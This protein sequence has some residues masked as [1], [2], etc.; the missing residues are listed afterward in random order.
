MPS[1][2]MMFTTVR[3]AYGQ[4]AKKSYVNVRRPARLTR[5]I[6]NKNCT[7]NCNNVYKTRVCSQN[8]VRAQRAEENAAGR[9]GTVGDQTMYLTY[10][11]P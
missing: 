3:I 2:V 4:Q 6:A 1:Y 11:I 7:E 9:I 10:T 8:R 5:N